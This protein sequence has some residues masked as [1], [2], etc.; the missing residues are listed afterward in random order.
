MENPFGEVDAIQDFKCVSGPADGVVSFQ[1]PPLGSIVS[2]YPEMTAD[3]VASIHNASETD[4]KIKE[5]GPDNFDND[6]DLDAEEK[7]SNGE[8]HQLPELQRRLK[9]RHLQ[10][11]AMGRYPPVYYFSDN[12]HIARYRRC[13]RNGS[14]HR[15]RNSDRHGRTSRRFDRLHFCRIDCLF[16][17]D[18][19]G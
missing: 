4:K 8:S 15:Y 16:R 10:M 13:D 19:T 17:H 5:S 14:F 18:R 11:I 6:R 9:S 1:L 7:H 3:E 2:N 12:A